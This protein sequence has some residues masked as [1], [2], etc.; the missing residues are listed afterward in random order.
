MVL[1]KR[2]TL[3]RFCS[4]AI[5]LFLTTVSVL[6]Q[7]N[8]DKILTIGRNALYFEDYV[9]AIQ[10][11][12]Q[13]IKAK[14]YLVE[15]YYYRAAAKI[16]LED[17]AG[18][19]ADLTTAIEKNPFAPNS[20]YARGFTRL[21]QDR[22]EEAEVDINQA[23]YYYPENS[24]YLIILL[25]IQE[26]KK[27]YDKALDNI[28]FLINKTGNPDLYL[29]KG[30]LLLESGDTIAAVKHFKTT[31]LRDSSNVEAWGALG[32]AYLLTD[33]L[34][35]ALVA[36]NHTL[37]LH[38]SN[39]HHYVNHGL[40]LYRKNNYCGAL[41]DFDKA[42]KLSPKSKQ[43]LFNRALVKSEI[44]DYNNA[45]ADLDRIIQFYP[46]AYDA[47][48]QRAV[49]QQRCGNNAEALD[50]FSEVLK[51]YP[52][53]IPALYGRAET[54]ESMGRRQMAYR[55]MQLAYNLSEERK[56]KGKSADEDEPETNIHV[57]EADTKV[58]ARNK[59]FNTVV[60][61]SGDVG[62]SIYVESEYNIRGSVQNKDIAVATIPNFQL[63]YYEREYLISGV[64]VYDALLEAYNNKHK[65]RLPLKIVARE[66]PLNETLVNFH[67][68]AINNN[69]LSVTENDSDLLF[70][71]AID[72]A[73][74]QN[75]DNAIEDL[76]HYLLKKD[77]ALAYFERANVRHKQLEY[78]KISGS[79]NAEAMKIESELVMRDYDKTIALAP[80]FP[81]AYF[82]RANLF[83][84]RGDYQRAIADYTKAIQLF[85]N[86]AEAFLNR[87]LTYI[88]LEEIE[89]GTADLSKAGELGMVEAYAWLKKMR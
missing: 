34:D 83:A 11:F 62:E 23:L 31:V 29:E 51:H 16:N 86:F 32:F 56:K 61:G 12:N 58:M 50:D 10:Y 38:T 43:A 24:S 30:R 18:A 45:V 5:G 44:G 35:N 27:E 82:N 48:F 19:E 21:Q 74:V 71:R 4:I 41:A 42:L 87:G 57:A 49:V 54:Y 14:P 28:S 77:D 79:V 80:A 75:F 13:V 22:W 59:L 67:F 2:L 72:F 52:T 70:E 39:P 69:T 37:K 53:F 73:L 66:V 68:E 15:P 85:P 9:L 78:N 25:E 64:V 81:Y 47:L 33:S 63:T 6:A 26:H 65:K 20:Y 84:E 46:D 36:Y 88:Y 17:Y 3:R 8:T 60:S 7:F 1:N 40:L 76:T 55:D 89:K